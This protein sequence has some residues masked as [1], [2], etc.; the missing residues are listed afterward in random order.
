MSETA[1][2][3]PNTYAVI[4]GID[5]YP[6]R[7]E[8]YTACLDGC[9][10]DARMF[11]KR[12][13]DHLK[14]RKI[15][16]KDWS[17]Y[18]TVL[19][20][21]TK[22]PKSP[23]TYEPAEKA[24]KLPLP[25]ADT[26]IQAIY[27]LGEKAK[28]DD[29]VFI[30]YS[31]HG[32]REKT[33]VNKWVGKS[34]DLDET[35]CSWDYIYGGLSVRDFVLNYLFK[36]IAATGAHLVV[37][38]DSCHS[39]GATRAPDRPNSE[40]T[41][42]S[43]P[44]SEMKPIEIESKDYWDNRGPLRN[45]QAEIENAWKDLMQRTSQS[46]V[47][48]GVLRRPLG[49]SLFTGC[50]AHEFSGENG[51]GGFLTSGAVDALATAHHAPNPD[52][53][54]LKHIQRHIFDMVY[55]RRTEPGTHT[56]FLQ[57]PLLLGSVDRPFPGSVLDELPQQATD[58]STMAIPIRL[59]LTEDQT[60]SEFPVLYLRAGA[61]HGAVEGAEY[62]VYRWFD[63]PGTP[64][65]VRVVITK[66]RN[67]VSV[68]TLSGSQKV[69]PEAWKDL[70]REQQALQNDRRHRT[71]DI[72][73]EEPFPPI[74]KYYPWPT[75]CVATL[76]SGPSSM[77]KRIKILGDVAGLSKDVYIPGEIPL[78]F[79]PADSEEVE[80]FRILSSGNTYELQDAKG[81]ALLP[82]TTSIA[83]C[84]HNAA[85]IARYER[86]RAISGSDFAE[87]FELIKRE[88]TPEEAAA[89]DSN[90]RSYVEFNWKLEQSSTPNKWYV[91]F[92][93]LHFTPAPEYAIRRVYPI[94]DT[95]ESVD[96]ADF[97]DFSISATTGT[98][99]A[100]VFW[101]STSFDWWQMG[102][103]ETAHVGELITKSTPLEEV[104]QAIPPSPKA[105]IPEY[106]DVEEKG[107]LFNKWCTKELILG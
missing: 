37:F 64:P 93:I 75:G 86:L 74:P 35:L 26:I 7:G 82:P 102:P 66:V 56:L 68:I 54:S 44:A 39:G 53:I 18:L 104:K 61:I 34:S 67:T 20:S 6:N 1:D 65:E 45:K 83:T 71:I 51:G 91:N 50:L 106:F 28:K 59:H 55:L 22:Y 87:C 33:V 107:G 11:E 10:A 21:T 43:M 62:G 85:H 99:K 15:P 90:S 79:L 73:T 69:I 96:P 36:R 40:I 100:M 46:T 14:R 48:S 60:E 52:T 76:I 4:I 5:F 29:I 98:L 24:D 88:P 49:Y 13:Q 17:K 57:S 9:V 101:A 25:D 42:R 47:G 81:T 80:D 58:S 41:I 23:K 94:D 89:A 30:S 97:R 19:T 38:L 27:D 8:D 3:S 77:A 92:S 63:N 78:M 105:E 16:P 95:F 103:V 84:L 32:G 12:I 2:S 70:G 31:G 72:N